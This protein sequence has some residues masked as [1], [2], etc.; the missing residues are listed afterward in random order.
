MN[1]VALITG[2]TRGIG[3]TMLE[4]FAKNGY[5]VVVT[6]KTL[7]ESDKTPGTVYSVAE[8]I[9]GKYDVKA[10]SGHL[11]IK[12]ECN[13]S[14]V[15]NQVI[16]LF[17]RI[18]VLINNAGALWWDNIMNT[19]HNKYDL[20]N[21]INVRG[22]Y[23]ISRECIP[24][25]VKNEDGG[26]I[27]MHSPPLPEPT[28]I[29]MY[30]NKIAY[31]VSKYGMTMTAMGLS[32]ELKGT[33]IRVNSIWPHTPIKSNAVINFGLGD[34]KSWRTPDI[35]ADAVYSICQEDSDF[36]GNQLIDEHYLISK[37]V[38]NFDKYKCVPDGE[39][40]PLDVVF[41]NIKHRDYNFT[42]K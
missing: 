13:I 17:G 3:R 35:M 36:T 9:A 15:V 41:E 20:V 27:I 23:L 42:E 30:K 26:H 10:L 40:L 29:S 37:G 8:E 12:N 24:H 28:D 31:M 1:K 33:N 7:V 4:S 14:N 22:S 19:P 16:S 5:N 34:E 2:S 39:P 21:N 38:N 25:M 11:N 6:G 32:E 18:D